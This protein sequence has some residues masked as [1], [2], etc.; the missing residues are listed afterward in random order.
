MKDDML[1]QWE[2][3][4]EQQMPERPQ[5]P[6]IKKDAQVHDTIIIGIA[7]KVINVIKVNIGRPLML[8]DINQIVYSTASI[9][10]DQTNNLR[11]H[12]E[13]KEKTY[14]EGE[15]GERNPE[16]MSDLSVLAENKMQ[17]GSRIRE[18]REKQLKKWCNIKNT[19][20]IPVVREKLKQQ[21]QAKAQKIC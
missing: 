10:T 17:K 15:N 5:L 14:L 4:K 8:T 18:R 11:K 12:V 6:K 3:V 16:K 9:V 7:N 1:R 13:T 19:T 21:I 20:D 2:E